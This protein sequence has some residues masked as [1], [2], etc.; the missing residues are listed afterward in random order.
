MIFKSI[1]EQQRI[2]QLYLG[3]YGHGI[4]MKNQDLELRS[5]L[6][7]KLEDIKCVRRSKS[8]GS[9]THQRVTHRDCPFKL[10]NIK[11]NKAKKNR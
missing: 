8:Y 6:N 5:K 2:E 1:F 10:K 7:L 9:L 4:G 11:A 3:D